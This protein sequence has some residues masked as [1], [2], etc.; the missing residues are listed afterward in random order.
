MNTIISGQTI[1]LSDQFASIK[2]TIEELPEFSN[3]LKICLFN[4]EQKSLTFKTEKIHPK[5]IKNNIISVMLLFSN[6]HPISVKTGIFLSEPRSRSFWQRLFDCSSMNPPEKLKKTITSWTSSSP[7]IL[8][9]YLLKGEYSDK[10]MLFFDC[11]EALPTNQYSDLKKLFSG[12]E[13]RKLRKQALQNPGYKNIIG[14]SQR[15]YIKS[16]IVFSAEAYRYIV[17]EKDI[18]KYAPDR[19][20]KA[21]DDYTINKNTNIFWESL[22]DLKKKIRHNTYEVTVYLSLIARRKNWEARNGEKYFTIMLNQ[23]F[24]HILVNYL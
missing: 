9:E 23:I 24:D 22:K 11:L 8:S 16:W 6:P 12:K 7:N 14:I 19:I 2:K 17:G 5:Y 4:N 13:G 1:L 3:L 10:I 20:C 18:A 15:N 21:I